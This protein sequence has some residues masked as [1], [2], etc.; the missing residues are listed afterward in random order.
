MCFLCAL[1][2]IWG[3]GYIYIRVELSRAALK[4]S[5]G[6]YLVLA[7]FTCRTGWQV[8]KC[9]NQIGQR[10]LGDCSGEMFLVPPRLA[11]CRLRQLPHNHTA[12]AG[13]VNKSKKLFFTKLN[14]NSCQTFF[15][16]LTPCLH[17]M[18]AA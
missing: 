17:Q 13:T 16:L 5:A 14:R 2:C 3:D 7:L 15:W 9:S 12:C 6:S 11:S 8:D 18:R 1:G 4:E 10:S